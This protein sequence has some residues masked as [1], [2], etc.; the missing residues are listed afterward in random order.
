VKEWLENDPVALPKDP[1]HRKD[2]N[3]KKGVD[4]GCSA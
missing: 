1:G 2:M 4:D 3:K